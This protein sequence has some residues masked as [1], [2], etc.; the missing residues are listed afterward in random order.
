VFALGI[1][2]IGAGFSRDYELVVNGNAATTDAGLDKSRGPAVPGLFS[3]APR[4]V[5]VRPGGDEI[6]ERDR[7][8]TPISKITIA[9]QAQSRSIHETKLST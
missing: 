1:I 6:D 2:S 3:R 9:M 7:W 5:C 4:R 8:F